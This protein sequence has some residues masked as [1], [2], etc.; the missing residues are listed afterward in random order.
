MPTSAFAAFL[1]LAARAMGQGASRDGTGSSAT[2]SAKRPSSAA[3]SLRASAV[4]SARVL[5]SVDLAR[6]IEARGADVELVRCEGDDTPD[7]ASSAAALGVDVSQIV[8][9]LV[10]AADGAFVVVVSNG[11][12]RVDVKKLARAL[13]V[14][15]RRVRLA[16]P[17]ETVVASGFVPGTVPPFGHRAPLRTFVD[18]AV[19]L[20][21]GGVVF[22]GGGD[23][24]MEVRADVRE[25]LRLTNAELVDLKV[26]PKKFQNPEQAKNTPA[27]NTPAK[28]TPA[29]NTPKNTPA[30]H[31][32]A[33]APTATATS[34]KLAS[35]YDERV[36]TERRPLSRDVVEVLGVTPTVAVTAA[37]NAAAA[38]PVAVRVVAEV[39]RVR[40]VARLLAFATL[41]PLGAPVTVELDA[42]DRAARR[43]SE[44]DGDERGFSSATFAGEALPLAAGTELQLIA[45]RSLMAR[46]GG[47]SAMETA[48][49]ALRQGDVVEVEGRLQAN[50][51]P[52]TVDIVAR[53]MTRVEGAAAVR[54]LARADAEDDAARDARDD[55]IAAR[56]E[57][58]ET[59]LE[60]P[61][62]T[63]VFETNAAPRSRWQ[64]REAK[65]EEW[66]VGPSAATAA[67]A[68]ATSM[69]SMTSETSSSSETF[70][71]LRAGDREGKTIRFPSLPP[72][73]VSWV[74]DAEGALAARDAIFGDGS[75]PAAREP[76]L[77]EIRVV[78]L[79]AEWR[80]QTG[81]PVAL[82]QLATRDRAFLVDA[83]A[84]ASED[85]A[86]EDVAALDA[87]LSDV[88]SDATILKIGFGFAHDL[89]RLRRSYPRL[90]ATR[91]ATP[92]RVVDAR[93]VAVVAFPEKRKLAKSGLAVVVASVLGAYVDKTEQCSD[94]QR[95]PLTRAQLAYA[96]A[97]AHCLTVVFDRCACAAPDAIA[98]ALADPD[99]NLLAEPPRVG[100]G[101][102]RGHAAKTKTKTTKTI[103]RPPSGPPMTPADVVASVGRSFDGR[104]AVVAALTGGA[105]DP[106][107][108]GRGGAETCGE[109]VVLYVNV[110]SGKNRRYANEFWVERGRDGAPSVLMSWFAGSG[111]GARSVATILAAASPFENRGSGE[112]DAGHVDERHVDE[113]HVD[114]R[115]D[116]EARTDAGRRATAVLYLRADRGPY[117]CCGR[118]V[119][120]A[121][122][123]EREGGA[124]VDFRLEDAE[125]LAKSGRFD[126]LV[127]KH[128][129]DPEDRRVFGEGEED[130]KGAGG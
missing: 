23:G 124:R 96:A 94:W 18:A 44:G 86:D 12:T 106:R 60:S 97:D 110:G 69:T 39:L 99:P 120:A 111:G 71:R 38:D 61:P 108:G 20:V 52:M 67:M 62:E 24:D 5:T 122:D 66:G 46:L 34:Q 22:G 32:S 112:G 107:G 119:A 43:A 25:L 45:G 54:R 105:E 77:D 57:R 84:M 123:L 78:G 56:D 91:D 88:V 30:K 90:A 113:R 130:A 9:S 74:S 36:G 100:G 81:S 3:T 65:E 33:S 41:R 31:T 19:P 13:G 4:P 49:R 35:A 50:P 16:T 58:D 104:K 121:T 37:A 63:N 26:S 92:T 80:P 11:E 15:N 70:A 89:A 42:H 127:G 101:E 51:R 128:M 21:P 103:D 59:T 79:D 116:G 6:W 126:A 125:A 68:A 85:A 87:L 129:R 75:R 14:A 48:L 29:K 93:A 72:A 109:F 2:A 40:R 98:A 64:T 117:V 8:K 114:E 95:R 102:S 53:S 28:N 1:P 76:T 83:L 7:V 47:A 27:K 73:S 10:F 82:L 115:V 17:E 55:R 118:L